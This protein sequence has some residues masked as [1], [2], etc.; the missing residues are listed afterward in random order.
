M[1]VYEIERRVVAGDLIINLRVDADE[2]P[3]DHCQEHADEVAMLVST[4]A[5]E[6]DDAVALAH[7]IIGM[8]STLTSVSVSDEQG[9]GCTVRHD[10]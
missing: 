8:F 3:C 7:K 5:S 9:N 4:L 1:P 6:G 2:G 10:H